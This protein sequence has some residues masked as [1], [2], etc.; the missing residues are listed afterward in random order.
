MPQAELPASVETVM[1][2]GF[3]EAQA[4]EMAKQHGATNVFDA[5]DVMKRKERNSPCNDRRR[6]FLGC[7]RNAGKSRKKKGAAQAVTAADYH[8]SVIW[9]EWELLR[10]GINK[11]ANQCEET[12]HVRRS[13]LNDVA[14]DLGQTHDVAAA[15]QAVQLLDTPAEPA[16]TYFPD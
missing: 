6:Y 15:Q 14:F 3:S 8:N 4:R 1:G 5:D 12:N 13:G 2:Y 11:L 10:M 9:P 16:D 7:L